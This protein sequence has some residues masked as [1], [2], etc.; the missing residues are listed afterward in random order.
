ML[1]IW[2][3]V[4]HEYVY[5]AM[6]PFGIAFSQPV[7]LPQALLAWMKMIPASASEAQRRNK[8]VRRRSSVR[9]VKGYAA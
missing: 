2:A 8:G 5:G 1:S 9:M 7:G 6:P 4:F 3:P